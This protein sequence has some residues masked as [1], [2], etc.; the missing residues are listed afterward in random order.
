MNLKNIMLSMAAT[1]V[2]AVSVTACKSG[3]AK[4]AELKTRIETKIKADP[5]AAGIM[6]DVKDG[7]VT[8]S[9]ECADE[10]S[11]AN[12]ENEAKEEKGVKSVANNT[13]VAPPQLAPPAP[14]EISP[15][16]ALTKSVNAAITEYPGVQASVKDGVVTLNGD[17][18]RA[19]LTKLMQAINGLKPKKVENKL[20]I[21]K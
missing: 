12:Y 19:D 17:I 20:N 15:D 10:A 3:A 4:D 14:V 13:T 21:I 1:A 5:K 11:R 2:L 16:D 9:G 7:V 18:K 8:L 6:V